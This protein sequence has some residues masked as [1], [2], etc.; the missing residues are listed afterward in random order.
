MVRRDKPVDWPIVSGGQ[1]GSRELPTGSR[2]QGGKLGND[3]EWA[4]PVVD[5]GHPAKAVK[6]ENMVGAR[7]EGRISPS[8]FKED[9]RHITCMS[10]PQG[11]KT[12]DILSNGTEERRAISKESWKKS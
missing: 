12:V 3:H 8:P 6:L 9:H 1:K 5:R 4:P 7:Y 11:K 2:L 10:T